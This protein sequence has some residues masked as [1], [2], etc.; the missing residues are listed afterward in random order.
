M[1]LGVPVI[2]ERPGE[3]GQ[4]PRIKYKR[5]TLRTFVRCLGPQHR[6]DCMGPR[7]DPGGVPSD[8]AASLLKSSHAGTATDSG[9]ATA[10]GSPV[11]RPSFAPPG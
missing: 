8:P 1:R 9:G 5:A 10:T 4:L 11:I 3:Q 2:V 7:V 6:A